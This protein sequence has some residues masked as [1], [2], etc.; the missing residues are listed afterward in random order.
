M[1]ATVVVVCVGG[2]VQV[3]AWGVVA[4]AEATR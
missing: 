1:V 2:R 4:V 3:D